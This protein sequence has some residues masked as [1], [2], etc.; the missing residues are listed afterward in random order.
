MSYGRLRMPGRK[1]LDY[2][3]A[4]PRIGEMR[5]PAPGLGN[6]LLFETGTTVFPTLQVYRGPEGRRNR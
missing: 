3:I 2:R 6:L 1:A 4:L 5:R